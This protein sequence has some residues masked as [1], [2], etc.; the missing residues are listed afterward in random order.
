VH[1]RDRL[2]SSICRRSGRGYEPCFVAVSPFGYSH[3]VAISTT[4]LRSMFRLGCPTCS[5]RTLRS[6]GM[7]PPYCFRG[8]TRYSPMTIGRIR[9][10]LRT[11]CLCRPTPRSSAYQHLEAILVPIHYSC[12]PSSP[13]GERSRGP[14]RNSSS[15][16]CLPIDQNRS[17][18]STRDEVLAS[19]GL[20]STASSLR[21]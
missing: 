4:M 2:G 17:A 10:D 13:G 21:F 3:T 5:N 1:R 9:A 12:R 8:A 18:F 15:R 14:P 7:Q 19:P 6:G 11:A 16:S 20:G